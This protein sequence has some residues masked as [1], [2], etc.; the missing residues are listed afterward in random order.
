MQS[1]MAMYLQQQMEERVAVLTKEKEE[2][3]AE[4][5]RH[6]EERLTAKVQSP[7]TLLVHSAS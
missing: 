4:R 7:S 6:W 2:S 3:L 1:S 5:D